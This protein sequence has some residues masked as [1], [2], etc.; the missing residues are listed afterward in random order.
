MSFFISLL[1]LIVSIGILY[2][3]FSYMISEKFYYD[4]INFISLCGKLLLFITLIGMLL[5]ICFY[6]PS[7]GFFWGLIKFVSL[8][9]NICVIF[10]VISNLK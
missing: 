9:I 1:L 4:F 2:V 10:I 3:I 7:Y 6:M 5:L 8:G